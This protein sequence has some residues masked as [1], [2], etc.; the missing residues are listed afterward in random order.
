MAVSLR[1][2]PQC[3]RPMDT[4]RRLCV[5]CAQAQTLPPADSSPV[6]TLASPPA[7][8]QQP[9]SQALPHSSDQPAV[10]PLACCV[11]GNTAVQKVSAIC[12]SNSGFSLGEVTGVTVG[13]S[14]L[15]LALAAPAQ[16]R[17][18]D[19]TAGIVVV[20]LITAGAGLAWLSVLGAGNGEPLLK[21]VLGGVA[22]FLFLCTLAGAVGLSLLIRASVAAS[23][24]HGHKYARWKQ[25][26]SRWD[27]LFYCPRCD[28]VYNPQGRQA[29]PAHAM[30][31]LL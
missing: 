4:S 21:E 5:F 31:S 25:A 12:R 6:P 16:P 3:S 1:P 2:C 26:M 7:Q 27:A 18:R 8:Y 20:S 19:Y 13:A 28:S 10:T 24:E 15:A 11:C 30:H 17:H 22:W 14:N 23:R 29:A 9:V